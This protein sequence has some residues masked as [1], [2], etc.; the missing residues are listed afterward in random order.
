MAAKL[1]VS[2][3]R[4]AID[5]ANTQMVVIVAVAAFITVFCLVAAHALWQQGSYQ[6]RV[7]S[8]KEAALKQL[9]SNLT[10]AKNLYNSYQSFV[11]VPQN[12]IQ[13]ST[14]GNGPRDGDNG[15]I[16]LDALPSQYD[17]PALVADVQGMI[18]ARSLSA[19]SISGT[20]DQANQGSSSGSSDPQP[21]P[22]PFSFS[23]DKGSYQS[24]QG[25]VNDMQNSIRPIAFDTLTIS[26]GE[27]SMQMTVTA[28]TYYQ[29]AKS[30]S[31]QSEVVK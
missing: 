21:Q 11:N 13:G 20:D 15:K 23:V 12:A 18:N 7:I 27:S 29:P 19:S 24:I 1:H 5:K 2:T 14:Q 26:G 31:I 16:V 10:A 25:L 3:K 17:F 28:H 8:K 6:Q 9:K 22:I 30:L 4:I